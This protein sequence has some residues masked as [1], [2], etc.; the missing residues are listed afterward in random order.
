MSTQ[1]YDITISDTAFTMLDSHVDFLARVSPNAAVKLM[2]EIL[3]GIDSLRENPERCSVFES[4]FIPDSRYRKMLIAKRYLI[5]FE[6]FGSDI[7]VDHIVDCRQDYQW[8]IY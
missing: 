5:I 4:Q 1:K 3:D 2:D 7:F 8:L 6:I